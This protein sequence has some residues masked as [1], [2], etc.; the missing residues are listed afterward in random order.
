MKRPAEGATILPDLRATPT[1]ALCTAPPSAPRA[2]RESMASAAVAS[3]KRHKTTGVA[4][5]V[6]FGGAYR[7][8]DESS[9]MPA[10]YPAKRV[11]P[12]QPS[13]QPLSPSGKGNR[14]L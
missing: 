9:A 7:L 2:P 8:R 1:P 5:G 12:G 6:A 3:A 13:G 10:R 14:G 4:V 11:P